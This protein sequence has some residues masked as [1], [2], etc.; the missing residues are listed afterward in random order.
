MVEREREMDRPRWPYH[1]LDGLGGLY[2]Q[3]EVEKAS[4][5]ALLLPA[6]HALSEAA[7]GRRGEAKAEASADL[8][9][10][11][12]SVLLAMDRKRRKRTSLHC[13]TSRFDLTQPSCCNPINLRT[14]YSCFQM[15]IGLSELLYKAS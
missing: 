10:A 1:G 4:S 5:V 15:P 3:A 13:V 7:E 11:C 6:R 9:A 14:S 12:S 2:T 8:V